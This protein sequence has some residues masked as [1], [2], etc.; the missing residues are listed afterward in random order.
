MISDDCKVIIRADKR[1]SG[2]HERRFNASQIDEVSIVVVDDENTS[3]DI[4]VQRRREGYNE[5]QR[6]IIH[7]IP[8]NIH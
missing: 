6:H 1:P 3:R 4:I 5:L 8:S 7:M 2:K